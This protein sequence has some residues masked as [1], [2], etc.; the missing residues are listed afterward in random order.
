MAKYTDFLETQTYDIFEAEDYV[1]EL[2]KIS[3][4]F[5]TFDKAL[6]TFLVEH[7]YAG[8][9]ENVEEKIRFISDKLKAAGVPVPKKIK[10]WY[11]KHIRITRKTAFQICFG[12]GLKL[13]EVDDFLKRICLERGF[14]CHSVEEVVY[15]YAFKNELSYLQAQ[16]ILSKVTKVTSGRIPKEDIIYTYVIAEEIDEIRTEDELIEYLNANG[17]K[18]GYNNASAC[19]AIRILWNEISKEEGLAIKEKRKLYRSFDKEEEEPDVKTRKTRKR[20]DDSIWEIYLQ[21]LGLSGSYANA[22]YS[23]RSIKKILIDN[24]MLHPLAEESFPDRN[25]LNNILNG[26]HVSY[27]TVRKLLILLAFYKFWGSRAIRLG[28]YEAQENDDKR[29]I[30]FINSNLMDAGYQLL[31][32][33]NPYDFILFAS[34]NSGMPL[35]AFRE[36]MRELFFKKMD[37]DELY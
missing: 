31:Y 17:E 8:D 25:G 1:E 36:Y 4:K 33:G 6:D 30:S 10:E 16:D 12:F 14:D 32:P 27:E 11:S 15:F 3:E 7:G 20:I 34:V 29:C 22:F 23:E 37:I 35:V 2:K 19:E 24:E 21:I 18:F 26:N 13:D 9:V 28:S 5:R